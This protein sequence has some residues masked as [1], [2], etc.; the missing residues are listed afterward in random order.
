MLTSDLHMCIHMCT[1]TYM[2]AHMHTHVSWLL[3]IRNSF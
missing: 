1:Y 3:K 2:H